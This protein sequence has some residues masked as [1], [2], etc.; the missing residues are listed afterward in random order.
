LRRRDVVQD[1]YFI[2]ARKTSRCHSRRFFLA[3]KL[4][5]PA[6]FGAFPLCHNLPFLVS[7]LLEPAVNE[8][9]H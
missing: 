6:A 8:G 2:I 5:L 1:P 7:M 4:R 3:E 9:A